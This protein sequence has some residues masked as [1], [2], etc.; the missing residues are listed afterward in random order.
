LR[1]GENSPCMPFLGPGAGHV[2]VVGHDDGTKKDEPKG[3]PPKGK[4][5]SKAEGKAPA[6]EAEPRIELHRRGTAPTRLGR[7][8][9]ANA[10]GSAARSRGT[11]R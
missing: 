4:K 1:W 9:P 6:T 5:G 7:Q 11:A 10:I 3:K 2:S 8:R